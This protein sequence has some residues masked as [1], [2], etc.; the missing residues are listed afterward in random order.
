LHADYK[1]VVLPSMSLPEEGGAYCRSPK[2]DRSY[3][4]AT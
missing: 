3:A 2:F 1:A 4:E